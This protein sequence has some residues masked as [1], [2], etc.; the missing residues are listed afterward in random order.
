MIRR[1]FLLIVLVPLAGLI[2][3]CGDDDGSKTETTVDVSL[4]E[5]TVSPSSRALKP[6]K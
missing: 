4:Q 6:A 1:T 2:W 3:A 5:W